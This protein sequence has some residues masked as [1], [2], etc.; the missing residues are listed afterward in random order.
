MKI[1]VCL[2]QHSALV[3]IAIFALLN[4]ISPCAFPAIYTVGSGGGYDYSTIQAAINAA[5]D[6]D[7][8]FVTPG[9]YTENLTLNKS[10]ALRAS[11]LSSPSLTIIDGASAGPVITIQT[12][13]TADCIIEG[14]TIINGYNASGNGGGIACLQSAA[15]PVIRGNFIKSNVAVRGAGI[16]GCGGVILNNYFYFNFATN[17]GGGIADCHRAQ[18]LNNTLY[19]NAAGNYGGGIADCRGWIFSS[20]LW[21]NY[22]A[23]DAQMRPGIEPGSTHEWTPMFCCIQSWDLSRGIG[24][25]NTAPQFASAAEDPGPVLLSTSPCRDAGCMMLLDYATSDVLGNRQPGL[26]GRVDIGAYEIPDTPDNRTLKVFLAL[27]SSN[28]EGWA[29]LI[30][31][32]DGSGAVPDFREYAEPVDDALMYVVPPTPVTFYFEP[33]T[34]I[35]TAADASPRIG[36]LAPGFAGYMYRPELLNFGPDATFSHIMRDEWINPA[37]EQ[38]LVLKF[39][40]GAT[41][42]WCDWRSEIVCDANCQPS[43]VEPDPRYYYTAM[44]PRIVSSVQELREFFSERGRS[45]ELCGVMLQLGVEDTFSDPELTP[46]CLNASPALDDAPSE[47]GENLRNF[48][49][50]LRTDLSE[51]PEQPLALPLVVGTTMRMN[52]QNRFTYTDTVRSNQFRLAEYVLYANGAIRPYSEPHNDTT[53]TPIGLDQFFMRLGDGS[54]GV[55]TATALVLVDDLPILDGDAAHFNFWGQV[56]LGRRMSEAMQFLLGTPSASQALDQPVELA[57]SYPRHN[58]ILANG[59]WGRFY[60]V[61]PAGIDEFVAELLPMDASGDPDLYVKAGSPVASTDDAGA[62][63]DTGPELNAVHIASPAA[64]EWHIGVYGAAAANSAYQLRAYAVEEL[65][66]SG[67]Y[68]ATVSGDEVECHRWRYYYFDT[69][70][71]VNYRT[72]TITLDQLNGTGAVFYAR[73]ARPPRD[74]EFDVQSSTQSSTQQTAVIGNML[75][76]THAG[77]WYIGVCGLGGDYA[78]D[79]AND[80]FNLSVNVSEA[81][82]P[83]ASATPSYMVAF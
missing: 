65:S 22:A 60:M 64:G 46:G 19:D 53:L 23:T 81:G 4:L 51:D 61:L 70:P 17:A 1:H 55:T 83:P 66:G 69:P 34:A 20:V 8:I 41:T 59:D 11:E 15:H 52:Y 6:G 72:M 67:G 75:N 57:H 78:N 71:D 37:T 18:I 31:T 10:V 76:G 54:A 14:F 5:S 12:A 43:S 58:G 79:Y 82:S 38:L 29:Y 28:M 62:T 24:N 30:D 74:D 27:G 33:G 73:R 40:P 3:C 47:Y 45:I 21:G 56:E 39:T 7:T 26:T 13:V 36:P 35:P 48:I 9:T 68:N 80:S 50:S 32:P 44:Y 49:E 16:A 42:L 25:I 2:K 77:R 63:S